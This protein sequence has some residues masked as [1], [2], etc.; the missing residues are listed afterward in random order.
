MSLTLS[1]DVK[2]S[3]VEFR[4]QHYSTE[5]NTDILT[6]YHAIICHAPRSNESDKLSSI[7]IISLGCL[8]ADAA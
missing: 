7:E 8:C 4:Q 1:V 6:G 3:S 2:V 5:E